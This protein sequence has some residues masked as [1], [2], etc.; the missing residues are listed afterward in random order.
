M[1]IYACMKRACSVRISWMRAGKPL[2]VPNGR[3]CN[4]NTANL[5]ANCKDWNAIASVMLYC[6]A[7]CTGRFTPFP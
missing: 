5:L 2:S 4:A 7:T 3:S 6:C 1:S